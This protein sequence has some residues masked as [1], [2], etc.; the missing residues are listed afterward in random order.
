MIALCFGQVPL[1]AALAVW[2][3]WGTDKRLGD[4]RGLAKH[5][6][7]PAWR[8]VFGL[9]LKGTLL[10]RKEF[11]ITGFHLEQVSKRSC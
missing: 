3:G 11:P 5:R 7:K 2:I 6:K 1:A 8:G 10:I 9:E 4:G